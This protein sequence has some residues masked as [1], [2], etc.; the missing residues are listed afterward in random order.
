MKIRRITLIVLLVLTALFLA[1]VRF[2]K[3]EQ[4]FSRQDFL[5]TGQNLV[6][7]RGVP[8]LVSL[9]HKVEK[10]QNFSRSQGELTS[11]VV[12][13]LF[14]KIELRSTD[15][16]E[17]NVLATVLAEDEAILRQLEVV[18]TVSGTEI[19]YELSGNVEKTG[20]QE[21]GVNYVVEV[22]AGM[23]VRLEQNFGSVDIMGFVGFLDLE[24]NFSE[25]SIHGLQ[26]SAAIESQFGVLNLREI[27]GPLT[28]DANF[29]T[30]LIDLLSIDG[31]YSF[32]I[33]VSS[34]TLGG[35]I[36]LHK[37]SKQNMIV[38]HGNSG[39]GVHPILVR[40]N[41][42]NVTLNLSK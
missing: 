8:G 2:F 36:P 38:A 25:V 41:F 33:D 18:E 30:S 40:S 20:S 37:S 1:D 26:G 24:A 42:G 12:E 39:D 19:R 28:L 5:G 21:Y 11:L 35:N 14:G 15:G 32:Q 27:A 3:I 34:G 31:G 23:E 17:L 10:E 29:T 16:T 13:G 6:R 7:F 9:H 22:P 4:Y